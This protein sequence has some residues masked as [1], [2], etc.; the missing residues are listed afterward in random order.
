[1][2]QRKFTDEILDDQMAEILRA[3]TPAE[4]LAIGFGMWRFA[5]RMIL[6]NLRRQHGDWTE[7]MCLR[8]T[9]RRMS[10]GASETVPSPG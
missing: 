6:A 10:H 2:T 8:E 9:A 1:M 3:K 7:E 5:S 4:R